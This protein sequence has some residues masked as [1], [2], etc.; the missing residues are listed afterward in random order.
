MTRRDAS[1]TVDALER[2][3]LL[4]E[5]LFSR[6][7]CQLIQDHQFTS[8]SS[9]RVSRTAAVVSLGNMSAAF[10]LV[11]HIGAIRV[12]TSCALALRTARRVEDMVKYVI[13]TLF[14]ALQCDVLLPF[15]AD[16]LVYLD[17]LQQAVEQGH[18]L[19]AGGIPLLNPAAKYSMFLSPRGLIEKYHCMISY[20]RQANK[21]FVR[22]LHDLLNNIVLQDG[23]PLQVFLDQ[24]GLVAGRQ[25]VEDFCLALARSS[26]ALP[27]I[28]LQ[29]I[30]DMVDA[31]KQDRPDY[32]LLEWSLML[33]L[34]DCERLRAIYPIVVGDSWSDKQ[35][36]IELFSINSVKS[37]VSHFAALS[38]VSEKTHA[39][40][41]EFLASKLKIIQPPKR[42]SVKDV[43]LDLLNF[44]GLACFQKSAIQQEQNWDALQEYAKKI[45]G[46]VTNTL[47][48]DA[49][50]YGA[51]SGSATGT[52]GGGT[53]GGG[54]TGGAAA[55]ENINS[56][57]PPLPS[58]QPTITASANDIASFLRTLQ[59]REPKPAQD[60][61]DALGAETMSDLK[62]YLTLEDLMQHG[63]KKIPALKIIEVTF[64]FCVCVSICQSVTV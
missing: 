52:T 6:L 28:S 43:I 15:D 38:T 20:R 9:Q 46:V 18:I 37:A 64:F 5:G 19:D 29:A 44:D 58:R 7:L 4:P 63:V 60:A 59:L 57:K 13:E 40:L 39:I 36:S 32:V 26:V 1:V 24:F 41:E 50:R 53:T 10:S 11:P 22:R 34:R 2:S 23:Q 16:H 31:V 33:A 56:A 17:R 45:Q 47:S 21:K 14:P 55:D 48:A 12:T 30:K 54:T 51:A 42:R 27:V 61:I 25:F 8:V 35:E 3:A 62:R 49:Y